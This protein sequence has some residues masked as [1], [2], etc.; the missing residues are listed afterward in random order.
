MSLDENKDL[1]QI[2][3]TRFILPKNRIYLFDVNQNISIYEL[4]KMITVAAN[5]G[6]NVRIF[7]DNIEYT[8]KDRY[9]LDELFPDLQLVEFRI[10]PLN[11]EIEGSFY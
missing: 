6:K 8:D 9:N 5:L 4:K 7:H 10:E 11:E 1:P 2:R 3:Q